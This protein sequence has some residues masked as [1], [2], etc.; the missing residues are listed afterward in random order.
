MVAG[1]CRSKSAFL[2]FLLLSFGCVEQL[3]Q[4][5]G[6]MGLH[7]SITQLVGGGFEADLTPVV[8]GPLQLVRLRYSQ[9]LHIA[10][11]KPSG[12]QVFALNLAPLASTDGIR[13]HGQLLRTASIFGMRPAGEA[14]LVLPANSELGLLS[15]DRELFQLW[16]LELGFGH[17]HEQV[18]ST[19]WLALDPQVFEG[20]RRFVSHLFRVAVHQ[21]ELL[22]EPTWQRLALKDFVPLLMSGLSQSLGQVVSPSRTP[23]RIDMVKRAQRWMAD[24][25]LEP[26]TLDDLCR[27]IYASRRTVIQGFRE[28][29]G[30]GPM[31]Y[32][33]LQ[34]LHAVRRQLLAAEPDQMSVTGVAAHFGF[35]NSGHFARD[36]RQLFGEL[37]SIT[38]L[39]RPLRKGIDT[40]TVISR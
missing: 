29:L 14:H 20:L 25:P 37:P 13:S 30:M 12:Q 2:P 6:A 5:A 28:H 34:R 15:L 22:Q 7:Y 35:F 38:L 40:S 4:G 31:A 1:W 27:Q 26:I 11:A 18:P 10:G 19:N 16:A 9:A 39:S 33:K 3:A 36:Y 24:H 17:L 32:L 8:L 21:P 23:A